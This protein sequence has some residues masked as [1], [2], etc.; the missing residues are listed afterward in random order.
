MLPTFRQQS[1][2]GVQPQY[3]DLPASPNNSPSNLCQ[4]FFGPTAAEN[5]PH[6]RLY[7]VLMKENS[8]S[9]ILA[10]WFDAS[11]LLG[12]DWTLPNSAISCAFKIPTS[13]LFLF[14]ATQAAQ[15]WKASSA[16]RE[17]RGRFPPSLKREDTVTDRGRQEVIFYLHSHRWFETPR[18]Q[19]DKQMWLYHWKH[20]SRHK[21]QK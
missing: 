16:R 5:T 15:K 3:P 14:F 12:S 11:L 10:V 21:R 7:K 20:K 18:T 19:R 9:W 8:L 13:G 17:Q 6:K 4:S 1:S 2:P